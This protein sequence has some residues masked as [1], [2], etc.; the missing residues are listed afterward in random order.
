MRAE[1]ERG[2]DADADR[3]ID[4]R[5]D[6][7]RARG[8]RRF[9]LSHDS[10]DSSVTQPQ[11]AIA[12]ARAIRRVGSDRPRIRFRLAVTSNTYEIRVVAMMVV[13]AVECDR[14]RR[15][16]SGRRAP[17]ARPRASSRVVH[18]V[19][20]GTASRDAMLRRERERLMASAE[21]C[22][23]DA[24][25]DA[26]A[27]ADARNE[28]GC[29]RALSGSRRERRLALVLVSG[30]ALA[31]GLSYVSYTEKPG[32]MSSS[33]VNTRRE[34]GKFFTVTWSGKSGFSHDQHGPDEFRRK[35]A[36]EMIRETIKRYYPSRLTDTSAPFEVK[37]I[38]DDC[39][40]TA[41]SAPGHQSKCH[42]DQWDPIFAFGSSPKDASL[43]PTMVSSTLVPL[44][45]CINA[46]ATLG[47][48]S[49]TV[50]NK[51]GPQCQFLQY[52]TSIDTMSNCDA[53]SKG[54]SSTSCRYFGLFN[55]DIMPHKEEYEW[56]NLIKK[57]VWRGSDYPLYTGSWPQKKPEGKMF[58]NQIASAGDDAKK[59]QAMQRLLDGHEI[60]PRMRAVLMSKLQP[61]KLDAKF[62]NWGANGE[63][64]DPLDLVDTQ[65]IELDS[66]AKY[67][68]QLDLGGGGGTTWS[69][70]IPKLSMPGVLFHHETIMKDSYFDSLKP[71]VHYLPLKEDLSNFDELVEWV[72]ANPQRA[73]EISAAATDWV[74]N[75]RKLGSL[76]RYNYDYL[77]KPLA[78]VLDPTGVL[79]PIPFQ[80]AHPGL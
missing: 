65:H 4:A 19:V 60:G 45:Y 16:A 26:S 76:L 79:Q 57:A 46:P 61:D 58:F 21:R 68:Y 63:G 71:Y 72:E 78:K 27:D 73:K 48:A 1:N 43:F 50:S 51:D 9:L 24:D 22:D 70:V 74:K 33:D 18:A 67:K 23:A 80:V 69:G 11:V 42:V 59:R 44:M 52:P 12:I 5:G 2:C 8:I 31:C 36:S 34:F 15:T 20:C 25:A 39:P 47:N 35:V 62:F 64:R 56:D 53:T 3:P 55:L 49:F 7:S 28:H 32:S 6:R 54:R 10:R 17:V 38:T 13:L 14:R 77:A 75:F 40:H 37:F 66:F 41:C 30:L 29:S